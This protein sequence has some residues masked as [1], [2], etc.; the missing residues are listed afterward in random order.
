VYTKIVVRIPTLI[1]EVGK[2][3]ESRLKEVYN[4][5]FEEHNSCYCLS[6][7]FPLTAFPV[8]CSSWNATI[9]FSVNCQSNR[10]Y[11]YYVQESST[12]TLMDSE[13]NPRIYYCLIIKCRTWTPARAGMTYRDLTCKT[14]WRALSFPR[15]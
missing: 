11:N 9:Y 13:K 7:T 4:P 5:S 15:N 10:E 3:L 2:K 1:S 6:T 14:E 12:G 8:F